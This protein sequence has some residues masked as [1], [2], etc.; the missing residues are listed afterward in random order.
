MMLVRHGFMVVGLPMAG[1]T[2]ALKVLQWTLTEMHK[3]NTRKQLG[4]KS[5]R[6]V[7]RPWPS[8][9]VCWYK[10]LRR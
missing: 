3:N 5:V 6:K 9:L 10:V 2:M 4:R 7:L 8:T 1:K